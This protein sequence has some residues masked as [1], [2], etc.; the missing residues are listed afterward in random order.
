MRIVSLL[1]SFYDK[2]LAYAEL[3]TQVQ[4]HSCIQRKD[5]I[6]ADIS[7]LS[8]FRLIIRNEASILFATGIR[9]ASKQLLNQFRACKE[10]N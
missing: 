9:A 6:H 8:I 4:L 1:Y 5:E 3:E 7:N 10:Q 2:N